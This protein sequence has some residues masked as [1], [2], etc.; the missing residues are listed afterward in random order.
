MVSSLRLLLYWTVIHTQ[1]CWTIHCNNVQKALTPLSCRSVLR[2]LSASS[3]K[4]SQ[5]QNCILSR[6]ANP[7][8]FPQAGPG[9]SVLLLLFTQN[10]RLIRESLICQ[11]VKKLKS[12]SNKC[13]LLNWYRFI[14]YPC[15]SVPGENNRWMETTRLE[16]KPGKICLTVIH[17]NNYFQYLVAMLVSTS[18]MDCNFL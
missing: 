6:S 17:K 2:V 11:R 4:T 13:V 5:S 9:G 12:Y 10:L 3:S 1:H 15:V 18:I 8:Q 7:P 16:C 14:H